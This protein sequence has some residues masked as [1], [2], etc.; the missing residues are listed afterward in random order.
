M[1]V[2]VLKISVP[3]LGFMHIE[4]GVTE[5]TIMGWLVQAKIRCRGSV[6]RPAKYEHKCEGVPLQGKLS[7]MPTILEIAKRNKKHLHCEIH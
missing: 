3:L 2:D 6:H 5:I 1:L 4:T 7:G